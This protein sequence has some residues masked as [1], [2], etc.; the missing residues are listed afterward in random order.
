MFGTDPEGKVSIELRTPSTWTLMSIGNPSVPD[1]SSMLLTMA[2]PSLSQA[3]STSCVNLNT[4]SVCVWEG[5]VCVWEGVGCVWEG[6]VCVG[7]CGVYV[8]GEGVCVWGGTKLHT[9]TNNHVPSVLMII[10]VAL[11]M[12]LTLVSRECAVNRNA[13]SSSTVLSLDIIMSMHM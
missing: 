11:L 5:R 6:R 9:T 8:G 2:T 4:G 1:T 12:M 3:V 10:T 13:S 7:G